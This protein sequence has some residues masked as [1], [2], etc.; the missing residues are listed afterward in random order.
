MLAGEQEAWNKL[1]GLDPTQVVECS[2]AEYWDEE[3]VFVV[4][5]FGKPY[6]VDINEQQIREI[7][8]EYHFH[9]EESTH[10]KLLLPL[11]LTSCSKEQPSG[12]LVSPKSLPHGQ[13]FFKGSHAIPEEV[14]AHH[15]GS[16]PGNLIRAGEKLGGTRTAGGDA[17]V[18]IPTFPRLP[19]TVILWV[20]D[21][22][23]PARAQMLL[24]SSAQQHFGLDALW[25][26]LILTAEAL[27]QVAGPHH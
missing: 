2:G 14:L 25:A 16:N 4:L 3:D 9:Y 17:A 27:V 21:L 23:F 20:G 10:F 1:A 12:K 18:V 19:V 22:E 5:V 11:Y 7:G 24:D 13:A 26:A 6:L 8:P 15:F